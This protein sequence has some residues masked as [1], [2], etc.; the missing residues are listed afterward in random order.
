MGTQRS[1][2]RPE[3]QALPKKL[4][5]PLDVD[6]IAA[7]PPQPPALSLR[8]ADPGD[9]PVPDEVSL[10]LGRLRVRERSRILLS[11]PK[12][13]PAAVALGRL[14][15][16]RGGPARAAK[17]T[18]EQRSESARRAANARWRKTRKTT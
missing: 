9:D 2:H 15:G 18:P 1:S 10:E 3:G 6:L 17:L 8:A 13:N 14:G 5:R 11:M 12:K 7:R 16:K 4:A